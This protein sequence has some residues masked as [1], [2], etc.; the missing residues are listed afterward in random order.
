MSCCRAAPSIKYIDRSSK[1][2]A[3]NVCQQIAQLGLQLPIEVQGS[4]ELALVRPVVNPNKL[5]AHTLLNTL[6]CRGLHIQ[7]VLD[8]ELQLVAMSSFSRTLFFQRLGPKNTTLGTIE[9]VLHA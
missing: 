2:D 3:L 9:A 8:L 6:N 5:S 7:K 1:G 4:G